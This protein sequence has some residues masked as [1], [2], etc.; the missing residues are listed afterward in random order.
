MGSI[1]PLW[2]RNSRLELLLNEHILPFK[3]YSLAAFP[4]HVVESLLKISNWNKLSSAVWWEWGTEHTWDSQDELG[5]IE[6]ST[7]SHSLSVFLLFVLESTC[8]P[9]RSPKL[10]WAAYTSV[11]LQQ[12]T[13]GRRENQI[14]TR[15]TGIRVYAPR[16]PGTRSD[17]PVPSRGPSGPLGAA[18]LPPRLPLA[19]S[20]FLNS[21]CL[22]TRL[23]YPYCLSVLIPHSAYSPAQPQIC[24]PWLPPRFSRMTTCLCLT[25]VQGLR[26]NCPAETCVLVTSVKPR[27]LEFCYS[28]FLIKKGKELRSMIYTCGSHS[29]APDWQRWCH[30]DAC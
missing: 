19:T 13:W 27:F 21:S 25:A 23:I 22:L 28:L 3:N 14:L 8:W 11:K 12:I 7:F 10:H 1:L 20:P 15:G 30:Q 16:W 24:V 5:M 17:W 2:V 6:E 29:V 26:T 9:T 4:G 18:S